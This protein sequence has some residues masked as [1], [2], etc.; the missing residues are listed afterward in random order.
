MFNLQGLSFREYLNLSIGLNQS[1]VSFDQLMDDHENLARKISKKIKPLEHFDEY[2]RS[3]YYPFFRENLP[4]YDQKLRQVVDLALTVD[5]AA[6]YN[7]PY[8]SIEKIGQLLSVISISVPFKPDVTAIS[9][10][11]SIDRNTFIKYLGYL[12]DIDIIRRLYSS[13]D[14]MG[15][16]RKPSKIYLNNTNLMWAIGNKDPEMGNLR[17]TFFLNQLNTVQDV[18]YPKAGDFLVGKYT[19]EIG[20]KTKKRKQIDGIANAYLVKDDI[21]IGSDKSLPLWLFGFLY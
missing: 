6:A 4:D 21:E 5:L 19:F 14:G 17:E 8:S 2:L 16:M 11:I 18:F 12:E 20:G 10:Q 13:A 7:I 9:G 1:N 15:G 3:G